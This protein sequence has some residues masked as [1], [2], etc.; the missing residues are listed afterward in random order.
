MEMGKMFII[1]LFLFCGCSTTL[2]VIFINRCVCAPSFSS[3]CSQ[4]F[5]QPANEHDI[6]SPRF[7]GR[8][9]EQGA[10]PPFRKLLRL[11]KNMIREPIFTILVPSS[12]EKDS[13]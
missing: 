9:V 1:V 12:S 3:L 2:S 10:T 4:V 8:D 6:L 11:D 7:E 5:A 13:L